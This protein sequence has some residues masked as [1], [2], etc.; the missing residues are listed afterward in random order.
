MHRASQPVQDK[1]LKSKGRPACNLCSGEVFD[2]FA[3]RSNARCVHCG[4]LERTRALGLHI[5]RLKFRDD[6]RVLH[7][8]PESSLVN[9]IRHRFP[10]LRYDPADFD[11]DRYRNVPNVRKIDLCRLED[12]PTEFYDLI[13][14]AHVLEHTPCNLAYTLWHLHRMLTSEGRHVFVI[15]IV[16]GTWDESFDPSM[17]REMREARFRQW[18]HVR[19]FGRDDLDDS[20]GRLISLESVQPLVEAFGANTLFRHAIPERS[21]YSLCPETVIDIGKN[22]TVFFSNT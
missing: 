5:E 2:E 6:A 10:E 9:W 13:V 14:H 17:L 20:L 11:T 8:A 19:L 1:D 7:V 12:E 4:S 16:D 21:W 22:D 3:G 18:D 15:P